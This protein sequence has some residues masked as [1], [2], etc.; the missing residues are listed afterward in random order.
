M[1]TNN[2]IS[3][4]VSSQLPHFV[5]EDH[6]TFVRFMELYYEYLEQNDKLVDRTKNL[7][8]NY[9]IDQS[10]DEF[11]EQFYNHFLKLIPANVITD[12]NVLV[13][14]IQ[15]FYKA[16]GT[17]KSIQ[18]LL[19]ILF[20]KESSFYY[21][22]RDVLRA[23]DGKWYIEKSIRL[24][25]VC[26]DGSPDDS[27]VTVKKF[28]NKKITGQTSGAFAIVEKVDVYYN[29]G[30][31]INELKLSGQYRN[32]SSGETITA[33]IEEEGVEH[34][35]SGVVF[36]GFITEIEIFDGGE[37]YEEGT[38]IPVTAVQG[39]GA[40]VQITSVTKGSITTIGVID[41]GAGFRANDFITFASLSGEGANAYITSVDLSEEYHPNSYNIMWTTIATYAAD[42]IS[43]YITDT[44][45]SLGEYFEY[46]N[47]GPVATIAVV[48][49]GNNYLSIPVMDI[50]SNVLVRNLGALGK[51]V[52]NDG[53]TGYVAGENLIFTNVSGSYGYGAGANIA[54]VNGTGSITSLNWVKLPGFTLGGEGYATETLPTITVDTVG[55][56]GANITATATLGDGEV[57][58]GRTDTIGTIQSM[59]II[60]GGSGYTGDSAVI[61]L[62]GYGDGTALANASIV[63]GVYTYPGRYLNDDGHLSG[64]NFLQDSMYYQNYS[65]VVRAQESI[66]KYRK[67][68]KDLIHPI[69]LKL[70]GEY[71]TEDMTTA[72][73]MT[74]SSSV[75]NTHQ[76]IYRTD[77]TYEAT[78]N[79]LN[80]DSI[81]TNVVITSNLHGLVVNSTIYLDFTTGDTANLYDGIYTVSGNTENTFNVIIY[82]ESTS[83]GNV[84]VGFI[85]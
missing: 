79:T 45:E 52:I 63:T 9:D 53:G 21:P 24:G 81:F 28:E 15:D 25:N 13:K 5:R 73:I 3:D 8:T 35:L 47:T 36:S 65:Y 40:T 50:S 20:N 17:E 74:A 68:L 26:Y 43:T 14:N 67:A 31:L 37:G 39:T 2:R 42:P 66:N 38:V 54:T 60:T 7:L 57:L 84:D 6:E 62:T 27:L 83:T 44:I 64:Y 22:K 55:G 34:T 48:L 33:T 46:A 4:L 61:D 29:K 12:K 23:S 77:K 49:G 72:T 70:F 16:R 18:F 85:I 75:G 1:V 82:S 32:F 76:V 30:I 69:G 41:G 51:L 56:V 59:I 58:I 71:M 19:R 11:T 80:I 10:I 78:A